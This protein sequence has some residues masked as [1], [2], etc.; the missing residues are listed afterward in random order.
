VTISYGEPAD[1]LDLYI[2]SALRPDARL[3][4]VVL[5]L[6]VHPQPIDSPDV[7][8]VATAIARLGVVVGVPDSTPLR[9][10]VVTAREPAHLA[11][12]FLAVAARPEVDPARVGLAG[13][14]AGAS[15]ALVAAADE[16][17]DH[18][19]HFVS[20]FGGYAN[21]ERLLVDVATR[22]SVEEGAIV[23]WA[24]DA[25]IRRDVLA[26]AINVLPSEPDR[27]RLHELLDPILAINTP[28]TGPDPATSATLAGDARQ[29]YELFTSPSRDA[30]Q[31]AVNGLSRE[32]RAE[33]AAISPTSVANRIEAQVFILHGRPDTAIPVAHATELAAVLEYRVERMTIFGEFGHEQPG[34]GGIGLDD[35]PDVWQLGLYLRAIVA[36]TL[37]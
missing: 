4:A 25:G 30:A 9:N 36:A 29:I 34:Q 24:P 26:L 13:F 2:P 15:I 31:T 5:A 17:L 22:T 3:P 11:D 10:L 32:L 27:A 35:L 1:R 21:A 23:P 7:V 20:S 16:R 37:E 28:P 18:F 6:G 12:A 8:G 33:L 14:S 19:V